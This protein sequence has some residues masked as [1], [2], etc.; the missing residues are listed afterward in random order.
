MNGVFTLVRLS[1]RR[2]RT[3]LLSG[4]AL[5]IFFQFAI[6]WSAAGIE[7]ILRYQAGSTGNQPC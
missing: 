2:Y 1:L 3:F 7:I 5:L 4:Y 6:I